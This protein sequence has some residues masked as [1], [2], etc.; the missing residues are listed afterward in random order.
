MGLIRE[1]RSAL[2][3]KNVDSP[4]LLRLGTVRTGNLQL[5]G[6][7]EARFCCLSNSLLLS[8]WLTPFPSVKYYFTSQSTTSQ[9]LA[10][11]L[12]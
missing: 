2:F 6:K 9:E 4:P 1:T 3:Q 12:H 10:E 8:P 5:L 11:L 7:S